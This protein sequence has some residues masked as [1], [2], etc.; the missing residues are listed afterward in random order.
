[1]T[2]QKVLLTLLILLAL[3]GSTVACGPQGTPRASESSTAQN[4][5]GNCGMQVADHLKK[6]A[7]E[8]QNLAVGSNF[9]IITPGC[10]TF[11]PVVTETTEEFVPGWEAQNIFPKKGSNGRWKFYDDQG[12]LLF[13]IGA[14]DKG[15]RFLKPG[16]GTQVYVFTIAR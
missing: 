4:A 6:I 14:S 1:M 2:P 8:G 3:V 7:D 15:Q 11:L 13:E 12:R 16:K 9:F 5:D 10:L